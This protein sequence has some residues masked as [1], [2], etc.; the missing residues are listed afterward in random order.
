MLRGLLL[1]AP[2]VVAAWPWGA[3]A[4]LLVPVMMVLAALD[5]WSQGWLVTEHVVVAR[6][7]IRRRSTSILA[8]DKL[9]SVHLHQGP[10]LRLHGLGRLAVRVAGS[11]VVLP[12]LAYEDALSLMD[13]LN[14]AKE[15][16]S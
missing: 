7:G 13:R 4:L 16:E 8:R 6:R 15:K 9:Q 12:D 14:F 11:Q 3:L 2:A 1:A 10:L 5:W